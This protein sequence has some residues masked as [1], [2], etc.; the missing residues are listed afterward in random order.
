[1]F[2][3]AD[4]A[5]APDVTVQPH[6][7]FGPGVSV[8]VRRRDPRLQP[9]GGLRGRAGGADR[10]L[11]PAAPRHRGGSRARMSATSWNSRRRNSALGAK[12]NHLSYLGDSTIGPGTNIGAGT[13]TCNYDGYR[14]APHDHRRQG[15]CR[16]IGRAGRARHAGR[17]QLRRRG[18]RGDGGC[19]GGRDG[20]RAGAPSGEARPRG[21][22]PGSKGQRHADT[23][24]SAGLPTPLTRQPRLTSGPTR[25]LSSVQTE[26]PHAEPEPRRSR[27]RTPACSARLAAS[28]ANGCRPRAARRCRSATPRPAR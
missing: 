4:T 7:V 27:S 12:A 15:V 11:R 5:L 1:M 25:R 9:S 23:S 26:D 22:L 16:H 21:G 18:Q 2:L 20:V 8:A 17:W 13:I 19:D 24:A 14:Q 28:M 10:P 3:S 6:V